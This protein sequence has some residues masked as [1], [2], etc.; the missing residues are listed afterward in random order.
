[1]FE[2]GP[3]SQEHKH[4]EDGS[5]PQKSKVAWENVKGKGAHMGLIPAGC[6]FE[7]MFVEVKL[8]ALK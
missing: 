4:S 1:V 8:I 6:R 7:A 5:K 2:K 3:T